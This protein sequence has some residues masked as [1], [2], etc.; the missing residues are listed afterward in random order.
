MSKGQLWLLQEHLKKN[1]KKRILLTI[2]NS[3]VN[4]LIIEKLIK[5]KFLIFQ[6]SSVSLDYSFMPKELLY[7]SKTLDQSY[8]ELRRKTQQLET[9]MGGGEADLEIERVSRSSWKNVREDTKNE[10]FGID[11]VRE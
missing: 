3:H 9:I 6:N 2:Q 1:V 11:E 10:T 7:S 8:S 4:G 5:S